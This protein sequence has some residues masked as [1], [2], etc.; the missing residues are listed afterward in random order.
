MRSCCFWIMVAACS[1]QIWS[2]PAS[3]PAVATGRPNQQPATHWAFR[4][5]TR[6]A[7]PQTHYPEVGRTPIDRFILAALDK[8]GLLLNPEADRSTLIRRVSLDLT[9]LPPSSPQIAAFLSDQSPDAY[10]RMVERYLATPGY[11][12][13]W[14]K[15]WLD[16]A[17]YADSNGYFNADSDRPLAWKYRDYVIRSFNADKPYDR[18]VWE[19]LAGDELASFTPE[20][21]VTPEMIEPLTATHF[22]RN[23]PDGT[24]ESDGNPDEVRTDRFSVLEG[25][26][27]IAMNALLGITIQCARCHSHKF[28]PISR[29][30]YYGLQA[31][32][33]PAY[34]PD[35]WVK[36]TDRIVTIGTRAER[37]EFQRRNDRVN[38]QIKA[39]QDGLAAFAAPLREQLTEER[40][41][42]LEPKLREQVLHAAGVPKEKRSKEQQQLVKKYVDG[43]QI[44]EDEIAKRF[45]EYAALRD[46]T[47]KTIAARERDRPRPLEK[48]AALVDTDP[49]P[50]AHHVLTR[51]Q[52]NSQGREAQPGVP[53]VLCTLSNGYELPS[54]GSLG[55]EGGRKKPISSGRRSAFARWVT[56]PENPLFARTMANR[57][58]Q[59]HFAA[60]LVVTPDNLGQSGAKPTH[61]ELLDWL[62]VEFAASRYSVKHLHRLILRSAVFRQSSRPRQDGLATDPD[63]RLLWRYPLRRLDAEALRD[64]MLAVSG[65]LDRAHR[66]TLRPDAD[67]GRHH[68]GGRALEWLPAALGVSARAADAGGDIPGNLRC[69]PDYF[70]L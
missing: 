42:H 17:G 51:G 5:Q 43:L 65:E 30:E 70:Q 47:R 44:S 22:L 46:Q 33:F 21:D 57:V 45:A 64:A 6:P 24:G 50:P 12:E 4:L 13:R 31:I 20:G 10:E 61:P 29:E 39:L 11:G 14:G 59:H 37:D 32:L 27:Q 3:A 7:A 67:G 2:V 34:N 18:F 9:G 23:A 53:A 25:N 68:R 69:S 56:S 36:P 48:L 66:W 62:A 41:H 63:N 1:L 40:L 49:N 35:R 19:Q 15:Y 8:K 60:G 28:E 26:L 58:W 54:P 55:F 16:V 38:R 52:H